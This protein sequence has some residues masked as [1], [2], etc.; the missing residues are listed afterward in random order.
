MSFILTGQ[1][2]QKNKEKNMES[3]RNLQKL[4]QNQESSNI[5]ISS[6]SCGSGSCNR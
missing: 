5:V 2:I 4:P 3:L 1:K 6:G